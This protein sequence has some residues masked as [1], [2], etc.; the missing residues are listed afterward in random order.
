M[1]ETGSF[2]PHERVSACWLRNGALFVPYYETI[3]GCF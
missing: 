3:T 2:D 1:A